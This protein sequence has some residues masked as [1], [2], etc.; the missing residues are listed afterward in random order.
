MYLFYILLENT[1]VTTTVI[2]LFPNLMFRNDLVLSCCSTLN[3]NMLKC[4]KG[5]FYV[6]RVQSET[7]RY[8][9]YSTRKKI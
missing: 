6:M 1:N 2:I 8:K 7:L 3:C 4:M 5:K 9:S